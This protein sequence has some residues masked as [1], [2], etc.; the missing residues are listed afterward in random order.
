MKN[1]KISIIIP[2]Y[3]TEKYVEKSINS[4]LN[5]SYKNIEL[6]II[7]DGSTDNSEKIIKRIIRDNKNIKYKKIKN[8]GVAHARNEGLRI[9]TGKYVGFVYSDDFVSEKMYETLYKTAIKEKSDIVTCAYS[10]CY[11]DRTV[12]IYPKDKSVFGK[13]VIESKN[14]FLNS[15][16]YITSK[17][18]SMKLINKYSIEFEEDLRIFEDLLFCYKLYLRANKI[19]Y[20]DELFYNYNCSNT[21]S[22]TNSFSEKM[23]DVFKALDR[24][25][26]Y[27][28]SIYEDKLDEQ[29]EYVALKHIS[30]RFTSKS[31]NRKL[32]N[33]YVDQ[34]FDYMKCNYKH[35]K[36]SKFFVG[37]K[38]FVKK[39]K[40]LVKLLVLKNN[41]R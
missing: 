32:L 3:N 23:F 10:K 29:I 20:V 11:I 12:S 2:V 18:F 13:S 7:N 35:Y 26:E 31:K 16:P 9:A 8:S 27:A 6:I 14:I 4:I 19:S 22:L 33:K 24:L 5:Q 37:F 25:K 28:D 34:S 15:N 38:G 17:L 36:K 41:I 40:F 21:S 39:N 30:L 1:E